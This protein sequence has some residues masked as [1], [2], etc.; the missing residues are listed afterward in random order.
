MKHIELLSRERRI[1]QR[2]EAARERYVRQY[3]T[4]R[5]RG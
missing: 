1:A 2:V 3:A 5:L 4:M